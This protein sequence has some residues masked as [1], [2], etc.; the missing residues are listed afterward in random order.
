MTKSPRWHA[1]HFSLWHGSGCSHRHR[2]L[3]TGLGHFHFFL[4]RRVVPGCW[5]AGSCSLTTY[6]SGLQITFPTQRSWELAT[7]VQRSTILWLL[8]SSFSRGFFSSP[9]SGRASVH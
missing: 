5:S 7:L 8:G 4:L 3:G 2:T 9:S 1:D 6:G